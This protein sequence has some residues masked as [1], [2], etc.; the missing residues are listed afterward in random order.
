M[1]HA[2]ASAAMRP[3]GTLGPRAPNRPELACAAT[4]VAPAVRVNFFL[5]WGRV[6]HPNP[7]R[8]AKMSLRAAD[9]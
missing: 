5:F 7:A 3:N 8:S 1:F 6:V 2:A 9:P 4:V